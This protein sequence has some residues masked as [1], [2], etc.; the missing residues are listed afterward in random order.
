[1]TALAFSPSDNTLVA[2]GTNRR[3]SFWHYRPY[4]AVNRICALAGTPITADEWRRLVP[5]APYAPPCA[6]WK[7]PAPAAPMG[8]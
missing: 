8:G 3:L 2:G 4:Q 7:P 6:N 5:G 1:L